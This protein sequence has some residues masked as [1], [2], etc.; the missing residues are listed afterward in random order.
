[1]LQDPHHFAQTG[2]QLGLQFGELGGILLFLLVV[3][4]AVGVITVVAVTIVVC[5]TITI[6]LISSAALV[7]ARILS[8]T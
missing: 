7:V 4:G 8:S 1:V 3:I 2:G 6:N 5:G